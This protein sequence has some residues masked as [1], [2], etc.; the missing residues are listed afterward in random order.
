MEK[1]HCIRYFTIADY[2]QEEKWLNNM[3]KG[4]WNFVSTNGL[5]YTFE[6]GIPGEYI[7]KIDLPSEKMTEGEIDTYYKFAEECG[8][9]VVSTFKMG[10]YLRK[11]SI[12]GN[13]ETKDNLRAHLLMVNRAYSLTIRLINIFL[14]VFALLILASTLIQP[15]VSSATANFLSGFVTGLSSSA[16]VAL[17]FIFVPISH[18]LRLSMNKLVEELQIRG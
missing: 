15:F 1:K 2:E 7:Y 14:A 18:R 3:S 4:G 11:K 17:A 12:D 10:R 8:I 5:I 13:F 9:E 16:V 6:K